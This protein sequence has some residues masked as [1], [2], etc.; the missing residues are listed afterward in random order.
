MLLS[1]FHDGGR[2]SSYDDGDDASRLF[3]LEGSLIGNLV[4][5]GRSG[6]QDPLGREMYS[7]DG[8]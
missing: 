2:P 5:K 3:V 4:G 8:I 7:W 1:N 6:L